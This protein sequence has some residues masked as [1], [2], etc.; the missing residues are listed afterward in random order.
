VKSLGGAIE[1]LAEHAKSHET[2]IN[3]LEKRVRK[4]EKANGPK[5]QPKARSR[6]GR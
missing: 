1:K 3:R 5:K 4:L 2:R 6:R